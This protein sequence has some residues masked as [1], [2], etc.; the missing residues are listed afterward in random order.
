MCCS[1]GVSETSID[2]KL[3]CMSFVMNNLKKTYLEVER[4]NL[5]NE[6]IAFKVRLLLKGYA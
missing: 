6:P 1:T 2:P 3:L 5:V 4:F